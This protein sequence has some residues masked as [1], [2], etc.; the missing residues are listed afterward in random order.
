MLSEFCEVD[1]HEGET[2]P[3]RNELLSHTQGKDGLLCLIADR[4]NAEVLDASSRLKVVSSLS[5]G[6]EHIDVEAATRRGVYIT[7]TPGVLTEATA[8]FTWALILAVARRVAEGDWYVRSGQWTA[9]WG[10][11]MMLG[12]D[13]HGK[14]LGVVGLGRIGRAIV[15]R[16]SGFKMKCIYYDTVRLPEDV[17]KTLGVEYVPLEGLL[18]V[19]DYVSIHVPVTKDTVGL[20]N[21]PRLRMMKPT[22]YLVNTARG[23]IVDEAAL[24]KALKE[25]WIAGAALDVYQKEPIGQDHPLLGLRNTVLAPHLASASK[26]SRSAMAELAARNLLSVLKGEC[27]PSWVNP[28]VEKVR[29]LS[30]VKVI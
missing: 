18:A 3:S 14:T 17:E 12:E 15:Q 4:I 26:Q 5:V 10:P 13:V 19:S 27:P 8:D 23:A 25:K 7:Y 24:V 30:A 16:A 9:G 20:I 21:E 22:A 1:L 11:M 29:P 6:F 2:A 28:E